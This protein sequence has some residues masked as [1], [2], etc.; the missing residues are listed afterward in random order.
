MYVPGGRVA[1]QGVFDRAVGAV[2]AENVLHADQMP[3]AQDPLPRPQ[4][5]L[6]EHFDHL[7]LV[8]KAGGGHD[9][10]Q[11]VP[12][13]FPAFLQRTGKRRQVRRAGPV[14]PGFCAGDDRKSQR[15]RPALD[16]LLKGQGIVP[17][18]RQAAEQAGQL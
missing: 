9:L 8:F 16:L 6:P 7:S 5:V 18:C 17:G 1:V 10:R 14:L 3:G 15:S 13:L 4:L 12:G 11:Q 2:M